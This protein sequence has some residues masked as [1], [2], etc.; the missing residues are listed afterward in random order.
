MPKIDCHACGGTGWLPSEPEGKSDCP[1]CNGTGKV[2]VKADPKP[3]S[4]YRRALHLL[5]MEHLGVD[6]DGN[7]YAPPDPYPCEVCDLLLKEGAMDSQ[8]RRI[9]M[10]DKEADLLRLRGALGDRRRTEIED[11]SP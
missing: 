11:T 5:A 6:D 3:N 9:S 8:G 10:T 2:E 4:R 7:E 1:Y